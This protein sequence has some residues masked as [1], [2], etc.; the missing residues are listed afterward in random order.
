[1]AFETN[2]F[3]V[4][5][6]YLLGKGEFNVECNVNAGDNIGSILLLSASASA[7]NYEALNGVL[8]FSGTIDLK[9]VY[10]NLEGEIN[11]ICFSCPFS[12][13]FE[14]ES[15]L[16]G[17]NAAISVKV[18]DY[19]I[20]NVNGDNLKIEVMIA[21][22]GY[23]LCNNQV[24][25]IDSNSDDVCTKNE[26]MSVLKFVATGKEVFD[27]E[28]Q[29]NIRDKIK[30]IIL[31]E[32]SVLVRNVENGVNFVTISGDVSTKVAYI[33]ENDKFDYSTQIETFKEEIE[34]EGVTRDSFIEGKAYVKQEDVKAEVVE[35]EKGCSLVVKSPVC[36]EICAYENETLSVVKDL[37][38]TKSEIGVTTQ[39]FAMSTINSVQIVENKIDGSVT[40]GDDKPRIDKILFYGG[41]SVVLTNNYINDGQLTL[42]GIARTNVV[43]LNDED[44]KWYSVQLDIP[45]SIKDKTSFEGDGTLWTDIILTDVDVS[46]KKGRELLFDGKIKANV[47]YF[48]DVTN[49][50]ISDVS[51][52]EIYEEKDYAMEVLFGHTGDELWDIAKSAKVKEEQVLAQNPDV[53]FPLSEDSSLILFYQ[54]NN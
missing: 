31:T 20:L 19:S 21:Q 1:M 51:Q 53:V 30:K 12:S 34:I 50:V 46:V 18:I 16:N 23:V 8:N 49:A 28:C 43:Y 4:A 33:N 47:N 7:Q 9:I 52:G 38:S 42:E 36:T 22:S 27:V 15:I 10:L 13:K 54:K 32:S 44:N 48:T 39:S 41:S 17:Q 5:K 2:D 25:T 45:F 35:D 24:K 6:K 29:M 14:S 26:D 3:S 40:L 11:T 37:Y